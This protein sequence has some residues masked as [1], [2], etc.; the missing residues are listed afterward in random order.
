[1][2]GSKRP[3]LR[4]LCCAISGAAGPVPSVMGCLVSLHR[5]HH[6]S[7]LLQGIRAHAASLARAHLRPHRNQ[8]RQTT[9]LGGAVHTLGGAVH[10]LG[11]PVC[12]CRARTFGQSAL[13]RRTVV[14]TS[15]TMPSSV[16]SSKSY[17]KA[18]RRG[19]NCS[20]TLDLR[21]SICVRAHGQ[22]RMCVCVIGNCSG[23]GSSAGAFA[24]GAHRH[25]HIHTHAARDA[26]LVTAAAAAAP[27]AR[28]PSAP[29]LPQTFRVH[30]SPHNSVS[31]HF[32]YHSCDT[33][34]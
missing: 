34:T 24:D 16:T 12:A 19:R 2:W 4:A 28:L 26:C 25:T 1:M 8:L 14:G 32:D 3:L 17:T 21:A 7:S 20:C 18:M 10:T 22:A 30:T 6:V 9:Q 31:L 15:G 13:E 29:P 5:Q 27:P 11:V 33:D 23:A